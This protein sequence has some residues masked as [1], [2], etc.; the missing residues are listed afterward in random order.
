LWR[1]LQA[2]AVVVLIAAVV[3]VYVFLAPYRAF[4]GET[5]VRIEKGAG[6]IEIG[7]TLAHAGVIRFPWQL[8]LERAIHPAA[9]LQAGEYLFNSSATAGDVFRKL[10]HGDVYYFEFTVTEGSNMFDIARGLESAGAMPA[11]EFLRAAADPAPITDLAPSAKGLEGYLFPSTYRLSH[12]TTAAELVRQMTDQFRKQWKKLAAGKTA[13]VE[14]TMILASLVEKETGVASERPL[15]AGVFQNR[16][17]QGMA[18]QCDPTTIYAA[19]LENRYRNV[20]HRSDLASQNP[21][22]TYQHTGLPPGPIANPGADSIQAALNPAETDYLYF[23]AKPNGGG[24]Q[25]SNNLA[26]HAKA[27]RAYRKKARKAG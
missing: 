6:T 25:F 26:G 15:V 11:D 22:N 9:K 7:R 19:L 3:L 27:T 17:E 18:L 21:Y 5:F 2:S 24:H 10:A 8:W 4:Q 12:G 23:V 16:L 14:E 1:G 13:R 20:I